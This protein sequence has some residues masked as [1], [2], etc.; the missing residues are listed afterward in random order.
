PLIAAR[1]AEIGRRVGALS[2]DAVGPLRELAL[3]LGPGDIATNVNAAFAAEREAILHRVATAHLGMMWRGLP[4][5]AKVQFEDHLARTVPRA[6]DQAMAEIVA[7]IDDLIDIPAMQERYFGAR[8]RELARMVALVAT[9]GFRSLM[10]VLPGLGLL[11]LLLPVFI[12]GAPSMLAGA[13]LGYGASRLAID[14][15]FTPPP[16]RW[17]HR[18]PARCFTPLLPARPMITTLYVDTV[19]DESFRLDVVIDELVAGRGAIGTRAIVERRVAAVFA[20]LPGGG[21]LNLV[22][23]RRAMQGMIEAATTEL[24]S[25]L[26]VTAREPELVARCAERLRL[27]V[28]DKLDALDE[29]AFLGMQRNVLRSELPLM[30][31][32]VAGVFLAVG[33]AAALP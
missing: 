30:H 33:L 19:A 28:R 12:P 31:A 9:P 11:P 26:Q 5:A 10:A 20:R 2:L 24:L 4:G 16:A 8:P 29:M 21:L 25:L 14:W 6:V 13:L 22:I 27:R 7:S 32:T 3:A 15:L 17:R 18:L 1:S 23:P